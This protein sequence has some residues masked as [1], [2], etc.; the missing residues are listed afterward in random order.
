VHPEGGN[1]YGYRVHGDLEHLGY[2]PFNVKGPLRRGMNHPLSSHTLFPGVHRHGPLGI[3]IPGFLNPGL[4]GSLYDPLGMRFRWRRIPG[5]R[6]TQGPLREDLL[7]SGGIL[8]KAGP[9]LI[10]HDPALIRVFLEFTHIGSH[11]EG[12][13]FTP[14]RKSLR[15]QDGYGKPL[16]VIPTGNVFPLDEGI[17]GRQCRAFKTLE[18]SFGHRSAYGKGI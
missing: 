12:H 16:Q 15:R 13:R 10:R 14:I 8:E 7:G 2:G 1:F 3:G 9:I 6:G 5:R 4:I 18:V 11:Q 17:P